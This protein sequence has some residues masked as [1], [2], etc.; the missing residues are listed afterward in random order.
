MKPSGPVLATPKA[1]EVKVL[2]VQ[3]QV[4]MLAS[5]EGNM[6]VHAGDEGV[7]LVDTLP[8]ALSSAVLAAIRT[9][10]DK[11]IHFIVNTQAGEEHTGGNEAL[12]KAG[13][14]RPDRVPLGSG[15]GG[16]TGGA[17]SIVAHENVLNRMSAT[18]GTPAA[19][20][21]APARV[22]AERHVLRG[23]ERLLLQRRGGAGAAPAQRAP[24]TATASCS[25][26]SPT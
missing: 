24:P 13:P 20:R 9:I 12:A 6:V 2:H 1:G 16:N 7:L 19:A 21:R 17:T 4:Y 22:V 18:V 14:T 5:A 10:S 23:R 26:A 8:A 15:L 11:P 25:S 3:G